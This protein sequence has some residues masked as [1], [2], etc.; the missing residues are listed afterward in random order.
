MNVLEDRV[1]GENLIPGS[2][3]ATFFQYPHMVEGWRE[4]SEVSFQIAFV[5]YGSPP[6]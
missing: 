1:S 4:L 6:S 3:M 2:Y 5:L